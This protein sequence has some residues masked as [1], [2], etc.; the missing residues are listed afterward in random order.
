MPQ[1]YID[2]FAVLK[3]LNSV[4][5]VQTPSRGFEPRSQPSHDLPFAIAEIL[6]QANRSPQGRILSGLNYKGIYK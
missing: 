6:S 5:S 3:Y 4:P 2:V 1:K